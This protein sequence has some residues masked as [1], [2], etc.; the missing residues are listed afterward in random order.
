MKAKKLKDCLWIACGCLKHVTP[1]PLQQEC[2]KNVLRT[3][4]VKIRSEVCGKFQFF[5][6]LGA[7]HD[8]RTNVGRY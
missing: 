8:R 6:N 7:Q 3:W 4:N 2:N 1:I 5:P